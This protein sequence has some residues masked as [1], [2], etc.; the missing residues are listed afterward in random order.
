MK[1]FEEWF[2]ENNNTNHK[3]PL[4]LDKDGCYHHPETR[5]AYLAY[6]ALVKEN[7]KPT[8]YMIEYTETLPGVVLE[9]HRKKPIFGKSKP[10][11]TIS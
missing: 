4:L 1:K 9:V 10:L 6:Y 5:L 11:Y 8:A 7:Q 3:Y 2:L